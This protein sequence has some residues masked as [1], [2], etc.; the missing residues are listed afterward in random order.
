M[1]TKRAVY[2]ANAECP[3]V[4]IQKGLEDAGC[5]VELAH[6]FAEAMQLFHKVEPTLLSNGLSNGVSAQSNHTKPGVNGLN[7]DGRVILFVA[8]VG[9]GA[10]PL[11]TLLREQGVDIPPTMILDEDGN[12]VHTIIRA[13]QL[14]VREY[15]LSSDPDAQRRLSARLLAE[16]ASA[17]NTLEKSSAAPQ[18]A[19]T[20][21][22]PPADFDWDP[23]GR[24]IHIGENYLRLSSVEG[25]IF[26]L[27]LA[28]R[29]RTV[30]VAELVRNVLMRSNVEITIGARRLR[31]HVMRLRRKL[32]RYPALGMRIVNM[33]GTGY[34][35]I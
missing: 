5:L 10:I 16:R 1:M 18:V 27:L 31:P 28:N 14:G 34:M 2:L 24:V 30:P 22:K 3:D 15:V 8:T 35:L 19:T 26:D 13:L 6:S 21:I 20:P 33:R 4:A 11:L 32:E 25:H 29:N 7:A 23:I 9:V 17:V 12:D